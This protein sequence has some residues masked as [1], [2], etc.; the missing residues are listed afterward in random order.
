MTLS[1]IA[2]VGQN[3][4]LGK[5]NQLLWNLPADMKHFRDT[6]RG[7]AVIMGRK[8]FQSIGRALPNRRNIVVTR[9]QNFSAEGI[10]VVHSI[11]EALDLFKNTDEEIFD[12]GGAE[13][14]KL[15]MPFAN[16]L[17]VTHIG[18]SFD[19]DSYF[20]AIDSSWQK[21]SENAQLPDED[22]LYPMTFTVYIKK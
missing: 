12:I 4:E 21:E 6:T 3:N 11:Q 10:E 22:N 17:Y 20:P 8:T 13:L 5:N 19:A 16:K 7:H 15:G 9:D 2:A 18:A 14:Y 1:L